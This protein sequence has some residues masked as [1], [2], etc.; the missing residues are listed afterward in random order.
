VGNL[1]I[2]DFVI[3][4]GEIGDHWSHHNPVPSRCTGKL[5][6]FE[7]PCPVPFAATAYH[8]LVFL[9]FGNL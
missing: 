3:S 9:L 4:G 6:L 1:V 5:D 2:G 7:Q 8:L